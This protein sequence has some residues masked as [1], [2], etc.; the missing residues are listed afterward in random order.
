MKVT[1]RVTVDDCNGNVNTTERE[2]D[3][4]DISEEKGICSENGSLSHN[5]QRR[6]CVKAWS[7]CDKFDDFKTER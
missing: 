7:G 1:I 6:L 3:G 4:C 2:F 5:G